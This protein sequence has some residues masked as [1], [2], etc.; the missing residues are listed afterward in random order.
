MTNTDLKNKKPGGL[1]RSPFYIAFTLFA[2]LFASS[3]GWAQDTQDYVL[4][5]GDLIQIQVHNEEDLT[6][7]V[8]LEE[9]G[10]LSYPFLGNLRV[11]G[12]AVSELQNRIADGLR[13]DYLLNPDVRVYVIEYRPVY[14]NGEVRSPGGYPYV[15]GLTVQKAIALAGGLTDLASKRKMYRVA[16][17]NQNAGRQQVG[18]DSR[19]N[20]GDTLII[21]EGFF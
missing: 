9:D 10:Y 2:I 12:V 3:P 7:Q 8:R 17:N 16:E 14:V 11:S 18:L 20:P 4:G 5:P 13:G 15:P 19:I 6:V 21:E 1:E